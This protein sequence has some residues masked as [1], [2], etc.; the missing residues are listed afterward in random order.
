MSQLFNRGS[1]HKTRRNEF[2][3]VL[4]ALL[5][6]VSS[7]A[8]V[9]DD[10]VVINEIVVF[11]ASYSDTGNVY[12]ATAF[13]IPLSPPYFAG[14]FSNGP[15]WHEVV[16]SG[17]GIPTAQPDLIG[18]TNYAWGGAQT[19]EGLAVLGVP[20]L[21]LQIDTFLSRGQPKADQL[22][23]VVGGGNDLLQ[24]IPPTPPEQ[25]VENIAAHITELAEAGARYFAV[26]NLPTI[27]HFPSVALLDDATVAELERLAARTNRLLR[28]RLRRLESQ[29]DDAGLEVAIAHVNW[30]RSF[31]FLLKFP[32]LI[33]VED[34]TSSALVP[35]D[36]PP[37]TGALPPDPNVFFWFD[38]V[39][40]TAPVHEAIGHFALRDI[41]RQIFDDDDDSDSDSDSDSE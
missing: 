19:G 4:A 31:R 40:P 39:H 11:G 30:N 9:A 14:R 6:V 23:L 28:P 41:R 34:T 27:Q 35:P 3:G 7:P 37:C 1:R 21:G 8:V 22:F 20:N 10:D 15:L 29:L 36:C 33:G 24:P 2:V 13:A 5:L 16:A 25:I 26:P 38:N 12:F 32:N 17:L 18:G